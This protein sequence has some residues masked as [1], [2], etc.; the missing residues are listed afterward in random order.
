MTPSDFDQLRQDLRDAGIS[1]WIEPGDDGGD[2][3]IAWPSHKLNDQQVG[4]IRAN[5]TDIIRW[6]RQRMVDL[7]PSSEVCDQWRHRYCT[8]NHRG[9]RHQ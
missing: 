4:T 7:M 2:V 8:T 1:L 3:L 9:V 5:K 6:H